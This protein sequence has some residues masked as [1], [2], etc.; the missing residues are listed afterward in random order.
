[1]KLVIDRS[2]WLRGEGSSKSSLLRTS[3]GKMCCLGFLGLAC[4]IAPDR[5][6]GNSNPHDVTGRWPSWLLHHE[7]CYSLMNANDVARVD[8]GRIAA[9]FAANGVEVEFVDGPVSP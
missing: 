8:E 9:L 6:K 4:G 2:K 1:M 5:L 3:D 7:V